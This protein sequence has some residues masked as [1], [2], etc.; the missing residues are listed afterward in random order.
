[1]LTRHLHLHVFI[2]LSIKIGS[3]W[4]YENPHSARWTIGAIFRIPSPSSMFGGMR[5][6]SMA[7][8]A[9]GCWPWEHASPTPAQGPRQ[10][11]R[12]PSCWTWRETQRHKTA[13]QE[14][15]GIEGPCPVPARLQEGKADIHTEQDFSSLGGKHV[16]QPPRCES[17]SWAPTALERGLG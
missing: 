8:G 14:G 11:L 5:F 6:R 13:T 9:V 17:E 10:P 16:G 12:W 2:K 4:L 1:M 15:R 3:K 7:Q